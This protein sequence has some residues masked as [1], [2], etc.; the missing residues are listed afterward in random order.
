MNMNNYENIPCWFKIGDLRM[1]HGIIK[2]WIYDQ[3]YEIISDDGK[4]YWVL[5]EFI[6]T[7][8]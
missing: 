7:E 1:R 3:Y 8:Y 6:L 4:I 2:R 5:P